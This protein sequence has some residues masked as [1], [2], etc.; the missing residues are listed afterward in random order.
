MIVVKLKGGLGNQMFQYAL[1]RSL[2]IKNRCKLLLDLSELED[3]TQTHTMRH[4]ELSH[5]HVDAH[6]ASGGFNTDR[7]VHSPLSTFFRSILTTKEK[8]KHITEKS[9]RF[10]STI[11]QTV[12]NSYLDGYWNSPKYFEEYQEIIRND[13]AFKDKLS[14][15]NTEMA[16]KITSCFSVSLHIRR[17]DY[18][19]NPK[20]NAYHGTCTHEYYDKAVLHILEMNREAVFF[21]FTDD[22]VWV[23]ENFKIDA[24][25]IIVS[26]PNNLSGLRDM[27]LMNLCQHAII[28]NSTFSW[29]AAWLIKHSDKIVIAP[30]KWFNDPSIIVDDLFPKTWLRI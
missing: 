19:S 22:P 12:D 26:K 28:A 18:V 20:T 1:G 2:T 15:E 10:D 30:L 27:Q 23:K 24:D 9:N 25:Y 14:E 8:L 4:Y 13:F 16:E 6:I 5:F 3:T 7:N 29:W 17:G 21:V 11:I